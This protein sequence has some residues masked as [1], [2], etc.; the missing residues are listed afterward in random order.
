MR[1]GVGA[2]VQRAGFSIKVLAIAA[3]AVNLFFT[4]SA[5]AALVYALTDNNRLLSFDSATPGVL[6]GVAPISGRI[7]GEDLIGI[8]FRPAN[9]QLY[10]VG[11]FG[12][13]YTINLATAAATPSGSLVADPTDTTNPF[14]QLQGSRWGIDFNPVADRLRITADT[15]QNYRTNVTNGFT[16]TD[17]T[18]A[19]GAGPNQ[20]ETPIIVGVGYTNNFGGANT[21]ALYGID[22]AATGHRLVTI[23]PPN[24]GTLT[25]VGALGINNS[26]LVGFDI[27]SLGQGDQAFAAF[28][29]EGGG[30]SQFYT[31]NLATGAAT[32]VG[33]IGGGDLIDGIALVIPEPGSLMVLGLGA[34]ALL[35]RR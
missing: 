27:F 25:A 4:S 26:S 12:N 28:Q 10:A 1:L 6:L 9:N 18:L 19:Y 8:D 2:H 3:L 33:T 23:N 22:A 16:F 34:L 20:G 29:D 32:L 17:G 31:V 21:T 11:E 7:G 30:I 15:R 35:R 5:G 24:D 14:T 13:I